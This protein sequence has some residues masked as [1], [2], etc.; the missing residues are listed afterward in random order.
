MIKFEKVSLKQFIKDCHKCG[1]QIEEDESKDILDN[2]PL[3]NRSTKNSA[4]YDFATPFKIDVSTYVRPVT[5]PTGIRVILPPNAVLL[6]MP[7]SGYGFKTGIRLSN[8][9]GVIDADYQYAENEGHIHTKFVPGFENKV[10]NQY[11]KIMQG[12]ILN[13][14][15]VDNDNADGN[16]TGGFGSTGN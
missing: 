13:Y 15:T 4:G 11:D 1:F 8:T 5:I 2:L 12:I 9:I 14:L 6:L 7:R 16:R 10:F 3:P